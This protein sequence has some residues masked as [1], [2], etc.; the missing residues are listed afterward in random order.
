MFFDRSEADLAL[1]QKGPPFSCRAPPGPV[2]N[3]D[4]LKKRL[5]SGLPAADPVDLE[6]N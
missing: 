3:T 4:W 2:E 5:A 6:I 1:Q